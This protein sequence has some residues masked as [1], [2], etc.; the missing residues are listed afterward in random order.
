MR[1]D[2]MESYVDGGMVAG[3]ETPAPIPPDE[4]WPDW[5]KSQLA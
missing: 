2:D 1:L 3:R 5:A 4:D